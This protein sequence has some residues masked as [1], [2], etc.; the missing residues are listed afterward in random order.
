MIIIKIIWAV[1]LALLLALTLIG[2]MAVFFGI[3][4]YYDKKDREKLNNK[5]E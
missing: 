2:A 4:Y 1:L 5:S 3:L